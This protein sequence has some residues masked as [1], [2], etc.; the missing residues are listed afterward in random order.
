MKG[1]SLFFMLI[2]MCIIVYFFIK[3]Q[4]NGITLSHKEN[5]IL[6]ASYLIMAIAFI[7]LARVRFLEKKESGRK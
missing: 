6:S 4:F 3:E 5:M 2:S 7:I 1:L